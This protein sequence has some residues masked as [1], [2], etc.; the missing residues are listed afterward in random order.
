[1][2]WPSRCEIWWNNER[3]IEVV[4]AIGLIF[5]GL[6]MALAVA[7]VF[8]T[9]G[10]EL[11]QAAVEQFAVMIAGVINSG[12]QAVPQAA[13]SAPALTS[14]SV[15]GPG[16]TGLP[17]GFAALPL[18]VAGGALL[19]SIAGTLSAALV[20]T[21]AVVS[22]AQAPADAVRPAQLSKAAN[23]L[24]QNAQSLS[25]K[26]TAPEYQSPHAPEEK[27]KKGCWQSMWDAIGTFFTET[28][29]KFFTETI[30]KFFTQTLPKFFT[31]TLPNWWKSLP[32][33]LQGLISF[34][35]GAL[36]ISIAVV[37]VVA[38]G[39]AALGVLG[40]AALAVPYTTLGVLSA[41]TVI[42]TAAVGAITV[43]QSGKKISF[44]E[45]F[46]A[47]MVMAA[48]DWAIDIVT[49]GAFKF[50]KALGHMAPIAGTISRITSGVKTAASKIT[51]GVKVAVSTITT[52]IKT[53]A[54][55][56]ASGVKAAVSKLMPTPAALPRTPSAIS[57]DS[58]RTA[59]S[60]RSFHSALS[61]I[62]SSSYGLSSLFRGSPAPSVTSSFPAPTSNVVTTFLSQNF[63]PKMIASSSTAMWRT[64][65]EAVELAKNTKPAIAARLIVPAIPFIYVAA[66]A[67]NG[68]KIDWGMAVVLAFTAIRFLPV[69]FTP[70]KS[71]TMIHFS[72]L[73]LSIG[74]IFAYR[75][76]RDEVTDG[77]PSEPPP[78]N[79]GNP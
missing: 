69:A 21:P 6:V 60:M 66:D 68:K 73:A 47:G 77:E 15:V 62:S 32:G 64:W 58:F 51:S 7:V 16:V 26:A 4:E 31:E 65:K 71:Y 56:I 13:V 22:S 44:L 53:A 24:V 36:V 38:L 19:A 79:N 48:F 17:A 18:P 75:G 57:L 2:I 30:P 49:F 67:I 55:K 3:G 35:I 25:L 20:Q 27:K 8:N 54:S 74:K 43:H 34:G 50:F 76:G 29:P 12:V 39:V 11:A 9:R 42:T 45:G 78:P 28:L 37:A 1:L 23:G 5:V 72:A 63:K 46:V 61:N 10:G 70:A 40:V 59:S 41:I 52:G 33:W 14:P